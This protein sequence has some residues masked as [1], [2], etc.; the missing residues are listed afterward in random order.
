MSEHNL[1]PLPLDGLIPHIYL[2]PSLSSVRDLTPQITNLAPTF[3][4]AGPRGDIWTGYYG[5]TKVALKTMRI[6]MESSS[7]RE[8]KYLVRTITGWARLS[9]PN[10]LEFYGVG[11]FGPY[12]LALVSPWM[13]NGDV[14]HYLNSNPQAKRS[15]LV[16]DVAQGLSYLH[17]FHPPI[18]HGNLQGAS[19]SN[20][21]RNVLVR[22]SGE[23]CL[24]DF[25][26]SCL[27]LEVDTSESSVNRG[28]PRWMAPEQLSPEEYG[29][30]RIASVTPASDIYSFG[31]CLYEIYTDQ[32]P[33]YQLRNLWYVPIKVMENE[34]PSRPGQEVTE[35]GL[36]DDIWAL[37]QDC[38]KGAWKERPTAT[39][40]CQRLTRLVVSEA[41][42]L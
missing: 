1:A 23:A 25:G 18:V 38:W 27:T 29:I 34:R 17:S 6:T 28:N 7:R 2:E 41:S 5:N 10:L 33:F 8:L 16:L 30:A 37:M 39:D 9:H 13:E 31:M 12:G 24:A 19:P 20:R 22:T 11:A 15:T 32:V 40:V 14:L 35:R 21:K 4:D 36:S 3:I 42:T 26:L